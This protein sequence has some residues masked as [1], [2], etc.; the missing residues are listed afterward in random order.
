MN[1][2]T[3]LSGIATPLVDMPWFSGT[4][5]L[6]ALGFCVRWLVMV[7]VDSWGSNRALYCLSGGRKIIGQMLALAPGVASFGVAVFFGGR[8]IGFW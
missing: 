3:E 5:A 4:I 6:L 7:N 8:T 2:S 1:M